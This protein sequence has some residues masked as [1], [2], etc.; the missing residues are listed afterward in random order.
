MELSISLWEALWLLAVSSF[1][2]STIL[3]GSSEVA[4]VTFLYHFPTEIWIAFFVATIGNTLGSILMLLIGRF[5]PEKKQKKLSPKTHRFMQ[6][7]GALSLLF[8]S[9][10]IIGDILPIAAGWLRLNMYKCLIVL[11]IGKAVRY[12]LIIYLL[13]FTPII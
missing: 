9:L 12:L 10:P 1:T 5:F 8:S 2:S 6:R 7:Y 3:P 13:D 11:L 4:L